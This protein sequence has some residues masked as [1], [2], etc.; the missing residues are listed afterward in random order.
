[1][2]SVGPAVWSRQPASHCGLRDGTVPDP[3][4]VYAD[5]SSRIPVGRVG[6]PGEIAALFSYLMTSQFTTGTVLTIDGGSVL[7]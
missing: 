5:F 4:A 6:E 3:Q 2:S 7:A 1:M